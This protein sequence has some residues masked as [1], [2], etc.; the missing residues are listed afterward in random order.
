M[1]EGGTFSSGYWEPEATADSEKVQQSLD[2]ALEKN[3]EILAAKLELRPGMLVLDVGCGTGKFSKY[4]AKH[5]NVR[6]VG[7]NCSREEI[8]IAKK[9]ESNVEFI[10]GDYQSLTENCA[11]KFHRV[12][13]IHIL[14]HVGGPRHYSEFFET[15]SHYLIPDEGRLILQSIVF[16]KPIPLRVDL[17]VRKHLV[18]HVIT[19]YTSE[20]LEEL[21][22]RF[23][24]DQIQTIGSHYSRTLQE[25]GKKLE[26]IESDPKSE[27][28]P[29]YCRVIDLT[30][31]LLRL[32]LDM[33]KIDVWQVVAS[34]IKEDVVFKKK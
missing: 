30:F 33:R 27:L 1:G 8:D 23:E 5:Y 9:E 4:I 10:C 2:S 32:G 13:C 12:V 14:E 34:R 19:P 15:L 25:Y 21:K 6:V 22:K 31:R 3:M 24:L 7:V 18:N 11:G 17:F 26:I 16:T 20:L 29:K 28:D